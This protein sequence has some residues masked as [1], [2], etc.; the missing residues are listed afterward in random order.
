MQVLRWDYWKVMTEY[1]QVQILEVKLRKVAQFTKLIIGGPIRQDLTR[2]VPGNPTI[3]ST[4]NGTLLD[5]LA[6]VSMS[7]RVMGA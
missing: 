4:N 6:S 1:C 3:V 5:M 2:T 7:K